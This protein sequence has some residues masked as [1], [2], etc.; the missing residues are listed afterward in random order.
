[1]SIAAGDRAKSANPATDALEAA[2]AA[3]HAHQAQ[4]GGNAPGL[5]AAA[6]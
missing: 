6:K 3:A 1:M 5:M 4:D 2:K